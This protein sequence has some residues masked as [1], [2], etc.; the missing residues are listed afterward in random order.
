MASALP[1]DMDGVVVSTLSDL[2]PQLQSSAELLRQGRPAQ[3]ADLL[4][5]VVLRWPS[6]PDARRLC[7]LALRDLGDLGGAENQ[8]RSALQLDPGSGPTAVALN[9]LLI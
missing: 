4:R 3:A 6:S 9:E 1:R 2:L 8:L 7:G 5:Q